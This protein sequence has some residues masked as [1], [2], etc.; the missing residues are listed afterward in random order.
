MVEHTVTTSASLALAEIFEMRGDYVGALKAIYQGL[1]EN[2][3]DTTLQKKR[4]ELLSIICW[5]C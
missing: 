3:Q 4:Q 1:C 2:P 5:R